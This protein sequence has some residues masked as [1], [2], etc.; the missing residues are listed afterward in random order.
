METR[1]LWF[2]W[3]KLRSQGLKEAGRD[4]QHSVHTSFVSYVCLHAR[5][6]SV[7]QSLSLTHTDTLLTC[8]LSLSLSLTHTH[9]HTQR[10]RERERERE[11]SDVGSGTPCCPA[12]LKWDSKLYQH[13]TAPVSLSIIISTLLSL[14]PGPWAWALNKCSPNEPH[15]QLHCVFLSVFNVMCLHVLCVCVCMCVCVC[16]CA[17]HM[18]T[19]GAKRGHR[20]S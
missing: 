10:E 14:E 7:S 17:Q 13:Q 3:T 8:S 19:C 5:S 18:H 6:Q 15:P 11:R 9:T 1:L 16:V 20:I 12:A 2:S 4:T